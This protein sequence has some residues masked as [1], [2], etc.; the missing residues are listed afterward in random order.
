M[1]L[2]QRVT[3]G[4]FIQEVTIKVSEEASTYELAEAMRL[5]MIAL[6]YDTKQC[7]DVIPDPDAEDSIESETC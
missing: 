1:I 5:F 4:Y 2:L 7:F 6:S 3:P